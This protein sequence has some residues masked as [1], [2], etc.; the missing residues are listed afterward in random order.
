[1][2]L[3]PAL[4]GQVGGIGASGTPAMS[5]A[6]EGPAA[7]GSTGAL[8]AAGDPQ[9]ALAQSQSNEMQMLVLQT[10]V[11]AQQNSF[12]VMSNILKSE[13]DTEKNAINNIK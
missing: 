3:N 1:L 10:Q 8:G 6:P 2:P 9:S 5:M 4:A 7:A 12:T 11:A 13:S